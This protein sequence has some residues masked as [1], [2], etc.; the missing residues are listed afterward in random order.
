MLGFFLCQA[1]L[2]RSKGE[3]IENLQQPLETMEGSSSNAEEYVVSAGDSDK[4]NS[5]ALEVAKLK[6][7]LEDIM[8]ISLVSLIEQ[9]DFLIYRTCY[10]L[11]RDERIRWKGYTQMHWNQLRG[12]RRS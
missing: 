10:T 4:M 1:D 12:S 11:K 6:V 3:E 7:M 5:L 8:L 2:D 9:S